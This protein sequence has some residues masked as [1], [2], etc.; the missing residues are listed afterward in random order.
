MSERMSVMIA[1]YGDR[2]LFTPG[3]LVLRPDGS[4]FTQ[5]DL[6]T[7]TRSESPDPVY[8]SDY[9]QSPGPREINVSD[10]VVKESRT[11][12]RTGHLTTN[13]RLLGSSLGN[14]GAQDDA[15]HYV[16]VPER[17]VFRE[18]WVERVYLAPGGKEVV[19]RRLRHSVEGRGGRA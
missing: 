19:L 4:M 12:Y 6:A 18:R 16:P 2:D 15:V 3:N 9:T 13:D 17:T 5:G 10:P 11:S 7:Y 1:R 8:P 14:P